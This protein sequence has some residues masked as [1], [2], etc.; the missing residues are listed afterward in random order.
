[1]DTALNLKSKKKTWLITGVAGF[2]GS[3]I[4]S[5]L[6]KN[7][8]R[9]IG[10]D[11][12]ITGS[13]KNLKEFSRNE[14]KNFKFYEG[15]ITNENFCDKVCKNVEIVLHQAAIGS[16]QRSIE[17]PLKTNLHNVNGFLNVLFYAKKHKIKKFIYASSSSVYG[18]SVVLPKKEIN[19]GSPLSPYAATKRFNEIYSDIFKKVYD[20]DTVGLRYFNVFGKNQNPNG[21]YAAVIPKWLDAIEKNKNINIYGDGNTSRD[22]CYI[23][24]VVSANILA[25]LQDKKKIKHKI[26]NISC[27]SKI[28]LNNLFKEMIKIYS[29]RGLNYKKKVTYLP[30]RRG[31]IYHSQADISL[32]KKDLNYIPMYNVRKGL[33]EFIFERLKNLK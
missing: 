22:F 12:F 9:V 2:I 7:N 32:A 20:F 21:V 17:N 5:F 24:N 10:V 15:D 4:A 28:S 13:K 23:K 6:I 33:K 11:N 29:I 14:L 26:F 16:V 30:S 27:G 1:M 19:L 3:N 18:D 8:Q 31:D 25:G